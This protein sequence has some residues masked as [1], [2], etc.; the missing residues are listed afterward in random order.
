MARGYRCSSID[1]GGRACDHHQTKFIKAM[2]HTHLHHKTLLSIKENKGLMAQPAL[3]MPR[4]L[5]EFALT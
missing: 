4:D 1:S 3:C 2:A 5:P